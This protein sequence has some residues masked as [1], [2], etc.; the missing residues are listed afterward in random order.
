M[1]SQTKTAG[2]CATGG[3]GNNW[4]LP[5][6]AQ[7]A[8]DTVVTSSTVPA[9]V[10][11]DYLDAT[12][13]GFTIPVGATINGITMTFTR[14]QTVGNEIQDT[15]IQLI[16]AGTRQGTNKS[17]AANWPS[18]LTAKTFGGSADLWGLTWTPAQI[19]ASNFGASI[20]GN[21]TS[22]TRIR[23]GNVD[24]FS[25]TVTYTAKKKKGIPVLGPLKPLILVGDL[26]LA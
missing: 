13:F 22:A 5:A 17:G 7:G 19:N 8:C 12:N 18:A 16:K 6:N 4:I 15:N 24:C 3:A 26:Q 9:G 23:I 11:T 25:I 10:N 2:T 21:N 1:A 14:N 20:R